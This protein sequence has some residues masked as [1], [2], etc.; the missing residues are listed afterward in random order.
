[1]LEIITPPGCTAEREYV[2]GVIFE[3]WLGL[4]YNLRQADV[5]AVTV[6][7]ADQPGEVCLPDMFFGQF[8]EGPGRWLE[9]ASMP[10]QPL[11]RWD[12]RALAVDIT[13]VDPVLPVIFGEPI[14]GDAVAPSPNQSA[15]SPEPIIRLPIDILGSAFFMLS[16]YE[17]VVRPDRDEH[18]RFPAWASLAYQEGFLDRPIV[19]EYVE[20]LWAAMERPWPRLA[21]RQHTF[22]IHISH[23][24][25][26]PAR[27]QFVSGRRFLRA[28][29]GDILKRRAFKRA[30]QG[31]L[32]RRSGRKVLDP[33]DPYNTFDWLMDQSER[34]GIKS[35]FY[36]ICGRTSATRDAT[37]DLNDPA[38]ETLLQRIH[39]RG[40]EIG[41]HPSFNTYLASEQLR[42]EADRL[43]ATCERLGIKQDE[44][45]GRMHYLRWRQPDTARAWEAA[46][47]HYDSTLGFADHVGFRCGTCREYSAYDCVERRK[48]ALR[49][50][51]LLV[52]ECSLFSAQY[53]NLTLR[54][55]DAQIELLKS[56]ARLFE[57]VFAVL[58]HNSEFLEKHQVQCFMGAITSHHSMSR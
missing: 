38:I 34:E 44:W 4:S 46:G 24:V 35:A 48:M 45:G 27:Y 15:D 8:V 57:G 12:S 25:D 1:M 36:F 20:V 5:A 2:L 10:S 13:L 40:H 43:H 19:D 37:Y 58:W 29:G 9:E 33:R 51:P 22:Q 26:R 39:V 54:V 11:H 3:D 30:I 55:A 28:L 6:R 56:R 32:I 42:A 16:R 17:E 49:L 41:L 47:L 21:R 7:L 23:D 31:P 52:M 53:M 50:R 14:A 18:D